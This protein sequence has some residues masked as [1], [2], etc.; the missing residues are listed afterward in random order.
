MFIY[1]QDYNTPLHIAAIHGHVGV[2][3]SL[4]LEHIIDSDSV[5]SYD[6]L[7]KLM[8]L[9]ILEEYDWTR[10]NTAVSTNNTNTVNTAVDRYIKCNINMRNKVS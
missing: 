2:I 4:L 7:D 1:I 6:Q 8:E 9:G 10:R 3:T 5:Y